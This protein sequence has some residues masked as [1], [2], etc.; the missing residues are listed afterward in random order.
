MNKLIQ[1]I[2]NKIDSSVLN[3]RF[4]WP[5]P[6]LPKERYRCI[7]ETLLIFETMIKNNTETDDYK[8]QSYLGQSKD[9]LKILFSLLEKKTQ[10]TK[11]IQYP[12]TFNKHAYKWLC[13]LFFLC[14][15]YA[16]VEPAFKDYHKG[17]ALG[18]II[19]RKTVQFSCDI[20]QAG[21]STL[22]DCLAISLTNKILSSVSPEFKDSRS[23]LINT[24]MNNKRCPFDLD[25]QLILDLV[26]KDAKTIELSSL[27]PDTWKFNN[28]SIQS[29]RKIWQQLLTMFNY[30]FIYCVKS[31]S[32]P[33]FSINKTDFISFFK[34]LNPELDQEI[35]TTIISLT[36]YNIEDMAKKYD[37]SLQPI[38]S[39]SNKYLISPALL[40]TTKL[41]RNILIFCAH[42]HQSIYNQTTNILED[43]LINRVCC[44][45]LN[46]PFEISLKKRLPNSRSLDLPDIDMAILDHSSKLCL[47][48][49]LKW[50]LPAAERSEY[51]RKIEIEQKA[52][53]QI[54]LLKDYAKTNTQTTLKTCFPSLTFNNNN[55]K[56]ECLAAFH[57]YVGSI[58]EWDSNLPII[59][60][61][62]FIQHLLRHNNLA[63]TFDWV[64]SQSF[65]PQKDIHYEYFEVPIQIAKHKIIWWGYKP[66]CFLNI[67]DP[68]L[69]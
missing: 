30:F 40:T 58:F 27:M 49:E 31:N 21:Y 47:L 12:I 48:I 67:D 66:T 17:L 3:H 26:N 45:L 69:R 36:T 19:D 35:I 15:D 25:Y 14:G 28:I 16:C 7:I 62:L 42:N 34:K 10:K 57:G 61:N 29:F 33:L 11:S 37:P 22:E 46:T 23:Q 2:E 41:E 60:I 13:E 55:I 50:T 54:K 39:I 44:K 43:N 5:L 64:K 52:K 9:I 53:K 4:F 51:Y 65:L 38:I 6:F 24:Q 20:K 32:P 59:N 8:Q 68:I 18:K 56:I 63:E 1:K